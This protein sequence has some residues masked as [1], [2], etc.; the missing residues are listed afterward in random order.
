MEDSLFVAFRSEV[1]RANLGRKQSSLPGDIEASDLINEEL[2]G[3][4]SFYY[5]KLEASESSHGG[6]LE[7]ESLLGE[8]GVDFVYIVSSKLVP[9][10]GGV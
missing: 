7:S 4:M 6:F 9:E 10:R 8:R 5:K 2:K 1:S 3:A